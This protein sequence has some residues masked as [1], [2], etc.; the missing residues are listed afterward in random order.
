MS[1]TAA[2]LGLLDLVAPVR[3]P[4]CDFVRPPEE[5]SSFCGA[6]APLLERA[7]GVRAGS[8]AY[9]YGGPLADAIRRYKYGGRSDLARPL[10]DLLATAARDRFPAGLEAIVSVPIHPKRL[11]ERGFDQAALLAIAVAGALDVRHRPDALVRVRHTP[12]QA[13]LGHRARSRNVHACFEVREDLGGLAVLVIDD[14]RTTGATFFEIARTLRDA[15][16]ASID[17]LALAGAD[18]DSPPAP[19]ASQSA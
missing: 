18:A 19:D 15:G 10:G 13:S 3:C 7:T 11:R 8:A 4:G 5:D 2:L 6:C 12:P 9:V 17:L 16:A 14:V 1:F